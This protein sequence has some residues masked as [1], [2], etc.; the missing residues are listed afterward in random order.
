MDRLNDYPAPL[1]D[2]WGEPSF[3]KFN[4]QYFDLN[5]SQNWINKINYLFNTPSKHSFWLKVFH[6]ILDDIQS[7]CSNT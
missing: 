1:T 6:E 4:L 3:P 7:K 5:L 2:D